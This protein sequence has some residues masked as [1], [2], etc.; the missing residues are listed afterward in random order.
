MGMEFPGDQLLQIL[1]DLR[2]VVSHVLDLTAMEL[3]GNISREA[4]YDHGRLSGSFEIEQID[5]LSYRIFTNVEYALFVH[6]GTRPHWIEAS[7]DSYLGVTI[8]QGFL[9]WEGASHPV[10]RVYHPGYA[11]N[12]WIDEKAIPMTEDRVDEFIQTALTSTAG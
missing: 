4:P 11:G 2:N 12:P 10:R 1:E 8:R 6:D 3:W 5:D 9:W 7:H